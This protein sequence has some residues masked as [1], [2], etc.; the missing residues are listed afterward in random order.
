MIDVND[1]TSN[2]VYDICDAIISEEEVEDL[3]KE[4]VKFDGK[5]IRRLHP[6]PHNEQQRGAAYVPK[7]RSRNKNLPVVVGQR[8]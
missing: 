4:K 6:L 5:N 8:R 7:L 2:E 1:S 3:N